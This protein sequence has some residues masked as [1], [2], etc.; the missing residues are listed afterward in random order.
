VA[1]V[2]AAYADLRRLAADFAQAGNTT[3]F[4]AAAE[5]VRTTAVAVRDEARSRAPVKT[6]KLRQS[7][8]ITM[9]GPL[10]ASVGPS[11]PYGSYQEF[12]TATRG[13]FPGPMYEIRPVRASKLAFKIDGEWVFTTLVKHPGIKA[14]PYMRPA[15]KAALGQMAPE[16]ARRGALLVTRGPNA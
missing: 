4:N 12:G 1:A 6:G 13:E 5:V 14:R 16:M 7:I 11:V 2:T 9:D 10:T 15:V 8:D 3:I